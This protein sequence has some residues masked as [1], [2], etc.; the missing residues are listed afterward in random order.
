MNRHNRDIF[1]TLRL[2]QELKHCSQFWPSKSEK[3]VTFS[4]RHYAGLVKYNTRKVVA[5]NRDRAPKEIIQCLNESKCLFLKEI[6]GE[7]E[8]KGS[9]LDKFKVEYD[10]IVN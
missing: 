3:S 10:G 5:K 7:N 4:I 6:I 9:I 1:V 2:A 8:N